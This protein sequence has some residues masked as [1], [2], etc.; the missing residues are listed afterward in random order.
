[1]L[2]VEFWELTSI[3][4]EIAKVGNPCASALMNVNH[5]VDINQT[6]CQF[7]PTSKVNGESWILLRTM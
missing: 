7:L 1:M 4:L 6:G 2:A 3:Y 5:N